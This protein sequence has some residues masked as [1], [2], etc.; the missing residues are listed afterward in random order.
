[1]PEQSQAPATTEQTGRGI[2]D[3]AIRCGEVIFASGASAEDATATML[4]VTRAYG[5]KGCEADVTH[6][7]I[8]LTWDD[9]STN[10]TVTRSRNVK[11]RTLDYTRLTNTS[12]LVDDLLHTPIS[13]GEARIRVNTI[14]AARPI[15]PV[16]IRRLGWSLVGAGAALLLGGG[17]L[18]IAAAFVATFFV[19]SLTTAL[20]RTRMS[21]FY[22]TLA[23][24]AVGPIVAAVVHFL[25][26]AASSFLVVVATIIVLL[27]GVTSFGAVQDVLSGFY[28]T[29]TARVLEALLITGGLVAGV[30]GTTTLLARFGLVLDIDNYVPPSFANIWLLCAASVII[31]L[32]FALAVEVPARAIWAVSALGILAYL[33]YTGGQVAG[34]GVAWSAAAAAVAVGVLSAL[35]SRLVRTPPL[36]LVVSALVPLVPGLI[37]FRGLLELSAG[38]IDGLLSMLEAASVAVALAAGAILGQYIVQ[39]AL[40]PARRIQRR[41]VGPLMGVQ[42]RLG[43]KRDEKI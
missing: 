21:V 10:D 5:L 14:I 12:T 8:T 4:A 20:A 28:V 17:P 19:D 32:G 9:P 18:V 33:V 3:L 37:L 39:N 43:R 2:L 22:Q 15:Y 31:I 35:A 26:P 29:G 41:F 25:D 42:V 40:G 13:V 16:L 36:P 30:A 34:L 6:T 38:S 7:V 23:G 24:G 11:Y 1:M 27:A